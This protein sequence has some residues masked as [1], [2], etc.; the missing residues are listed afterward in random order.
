[1]LAYQSQSLKSLNTLKHLSNLQRIPMVSSTISWIVH[2]AH[3]V[4]VRPLLYRKYVLLLASWKCKYL[5][6]ADIFKCNAKRSPQGPGANLASA[7]L[8]AVGK[9]GGKA[10]NTL[11]KLTGGV[12]N[13]SDNGA[14][15]V[16]NVAG[17]N[18]STISG[19]LGPVPSPSQPKGNCRL[20]CAFVGSLWGLGLSEESFR[21]CLAQS[22]IRGYICF[23][24]ESRAQF[25]NLLYK[26]WICK[27]SPIHLELDI[28]S[29]YNL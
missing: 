20:L 8:Q 29:I 28:E 6:R 11:D 21:A 9:L 18:L 13:A 7:A 16:G 15:I 4:V 27:K 17:Y 12:G 23:E 22:S 10:G 24:S 25:A 3:K 14:A 26:C 19:V 2:L 5:E 1:M